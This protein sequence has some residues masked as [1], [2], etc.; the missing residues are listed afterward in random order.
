MNILVINCGSSSVKTELIES[1]SGKRYLAMNI[2]RVNEN[3]PQIKFSDS[4]D[5]IDC[6]EAGHDAALRFALPKLIEKLGDIKIE[7]VGHRVVHGGDKF[8]EPTIIDAEVEAAIESLFSLAPL[9]NPANLKG[10]QIAKEIFSDL[11]HVAIFDTAFHQTLP[12]RAYNYALPK[13]LREKYSLR[14][15]GFHGTSHQYVAE[16]AALELG[17]D[18]AQ[19]RIITCH[20]GNGASV[21]AVE[22]GRSVE[23]SMGLT[24]LEG[25]VMGTRSGDVDPGI[26]MHIAR[27]EGLTIDELDKIL[28]KESGLKGS[29]NQSNDM[30]DMMMIVESLCRS[31]HIDFVSILVPMLR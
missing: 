16:Q 17:T 22:Y 8:D 6:P 19:L 30:R 2:E 1:E 13:A 5:I 21:T 28:N 26:L 12:T 25:L 20:L 10:I 11:E 31:L 9:H 24:P 23:T 15:Y 7:G 18:L 27:E 3:T 29:S 4:E 14:R